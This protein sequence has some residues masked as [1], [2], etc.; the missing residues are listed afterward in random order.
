MTAFSAGA[1]FSAIPQQRL[2]LT[3]TWRDD[4]GRV[5]FIRQV[6][7]QV[8]WYVDSRPGAHE[9][10]CGTISRNNTITGQW[11]DLPGAREQDNGQL[12]LRVESNNRIVKV[13]S[14][15]AYV[16]STWTLDNGRNTSNRDRDFSNNR[17]GRD[18]PPEP[19]SGWQILGRSA[20]D[21][22]VGDDGTVWVISNEQA[23]NGFAIYRRVRNQQW[24][25]VDGGAVRIDVDGRGNPW[26]VNR[27]GE[28]FRRNGNAWE[29][30]SGYAND[31][32]VGADGDVWIT[33]ANAVSGG[34]GIYRWN[35]RGWSEV[36][37]GAVRIDVDGQGTPWIVNAEGQIFRRVRNQWERLPGSGR[38]ISVNASGEVWVIGTDRT[39]GGYG[40][41]NW[42]GRDW[43]R[44]EGG[45][46]QISVGGD[47]SVWV[48]NSNGSIY[49]RR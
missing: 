4:R 32:G 39:D 2:D 46:T 26:V 16:A 38:D 36:D 18:L 17:G 47:G 48:V 45:G 42:T 24:G 12:T 14:T 10:F 31:I 33:G 25:R 40:I 3:G 21:I 37:G 13:R 7:D 23:S 43:A 29:Q 9:V 6:G 20:R 19:D 27:E 1:Q 35:G 22:G 11:M 28:I 30:V 49:R 5:T 15:P 44:V 41:F 34:F 8:C